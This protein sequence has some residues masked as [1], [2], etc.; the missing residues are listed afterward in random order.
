MSGLLAMDPVVDPQPQ[1]AAAIAADVLGVPAATAK[2]FPTGL[3]HFVYDVRLADGRRAVVRMSRRDDIAAA[4]GAVYWSSL[5]RPKGVPLPELWH[6]DLSLARYPFPVI[7]LERLPGDDLGIVFRQLDRRALHALAERLAAV[8]AVVTALPPGGGY[9]YATSYDG[10]FAQT[11]W[12]GVVARLLARSRARIRA[13][14]IVD[15]AIIDP[16]ERA[17]ETFAGYFGR[18]APVPFLHDITTKNVIVHDGRLSGIVDVDDLCFGDPLLLLGLIRM[19][20]LAQDLD[21]FYVD[22]WHAIARPDAEQAA[23][24]DLYTAL[25]CIDFIGELGQRFNRAASEPVDAACLARLQAL[26]AELSRRCAA[27]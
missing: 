16:I 8:Q 12:G 2:R 24:I 18:I 1:D 11:R 26:L 5:L 27:G 13:A 10:D 7:V 9:G 25:Y 17:A 19:A 3:A 22:A 4:R 14:G 20:L 23:A 6:A 15:E 21:P